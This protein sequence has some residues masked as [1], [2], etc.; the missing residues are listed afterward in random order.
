MANEE[1]NDDN[2]GNIYGNPDE[3]LDFQVVQN[4]YYE[5]EVEMHPNEVSAPMNNLNMSNIEVITSTQNDY[6][7]M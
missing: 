2:L 1:N 6:Y 7:K 4:P 5:G 3:D